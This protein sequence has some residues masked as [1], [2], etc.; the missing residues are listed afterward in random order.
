MLG[1][2]IISKKI[3][4]FK[5]CATKNIEYFKN[6]TFSKNLIYKWKIINFLKMKHL[7]KN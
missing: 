7:Q 2:F 4:S 1:S 3:R 5:K 6:W